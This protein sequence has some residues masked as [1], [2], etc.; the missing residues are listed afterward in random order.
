MTP[1]DC[2][3]AIQVN[4]MQLEIDQESAN[5][6]TL[7]RQ[8]QEA[9]SH[10]AR[11]A[12]KLAI[13]KSNEKIEA[14][15]LLLLQYC[16]GLQHCL[17][18]EEEQ[19]QQLSSSAPAAES[20]TTSSTVAASADVSV[21]VEDDLQQEDRTAM[22][23]QQTEQAVAQVITELI[24]AD[25]NDSLSSDEEMNENGEEEGAVEQFRPVCQNSDS[26]AAMGGEREVEKAKAMLEGRSD[27]FTDSEEERELE[28]TLWY[29]TFLTTCHTPLLNLGPWH[30]WVFSVCSWPSEQLFLP[31]CL[32]TVCGVSHWWTIFG[33]GVGEGERGQ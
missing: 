12:A 27:Q 18:Q 19:R 13:T 3:V 7:T 9:D 6:A 2:V 24:D 25:D 22:D 32:L 8:L 10:S 23:Q 17:D 16:A 33:W 4:K 5:K 28:D 21:A 26:K 29:T 14:L 11:S 15:M 20:T 31:F 30:C 1:G